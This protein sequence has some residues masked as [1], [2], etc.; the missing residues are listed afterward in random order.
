MKIPKVYFT[1]RQ[2]ALVTQAAQALGVVLVVFGAI[3][4]EK[5][6]AILGLLTNMA[7]LYVGIQQ[8]GANDSNTSAMQA[9][10]GVAEDA[11]PGPVSVDAAFDLAR[12]AIKK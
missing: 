3:S 5:W 4:T 10:A 8:G 11:K 12:R 9:A 7:A 6:A 2:L 1:A